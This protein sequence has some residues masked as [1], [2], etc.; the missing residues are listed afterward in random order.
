MP[1]DLNIATSIS[2]EG[3]REK[4]RKINGDASNASA[5]IEAKATT[6]KLE[7]ALTESSSPS[8]I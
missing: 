2:L 6:A 7:I 4:T 1:V 5:V 8:W 3:F